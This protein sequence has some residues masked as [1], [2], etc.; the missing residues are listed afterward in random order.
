MY[1]KLDRNNREKVQ[2][3]PITIGS[4]DASFC[5]AL[6]H[7]THLKI[8]GYGTWQALQAIGA[9]INGIAGWDEVVEA[10][11]MAHQSIGSAQP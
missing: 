2:V 8:K 10:Y 7:I 6:E 5:I 9:P 11:A 3:A 1:L 4:V